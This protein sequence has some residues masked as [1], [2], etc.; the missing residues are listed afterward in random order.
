[1]RIS[2]ASWFWYLKESV[3]EE[4]LFRYVIFWIIG[5]W[6]G[7]I[8]STIVYALAHKILFDWKVTLLCIPLGF[9]LSYLYMILPMGFNLIGC[10][11]L[12]FLV[13]IG[14]DILGLTKNKNYKLLDTL[15]Y[16]HRTN[17]N[18]GNY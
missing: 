1:M 10:I 18:K 9:V 7:V 5:G 16:I 3:S 13:G 2:E 12:H 4:V 6:V 14:A 11:I 17:G 15:F 8:V